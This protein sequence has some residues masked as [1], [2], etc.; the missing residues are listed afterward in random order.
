MTT[1]LSS[2]KP[3]CAKLMPKILVNGSE[4]LSVSY[5]SSRVGDDT[6]SDDLRPCMEEQTSNISAT[7]VKT[8]D[9]TSASSRTSSSSTTSVAMN[10]SRISSPGSE[11]GLER[12]FQNGGKCG[13]QLGN[14][15]G[16]K[17]LDQEQ[18]DVLAIDEFLLSRARNMCPYQSK[19]A[20]LMASS[21]IIAQWGAFR[22][23]DYY[24]IKFRPSR[25]R[26]LNCTGACVTSGVVKQ[27]EPINEKPAHPL[28]TDYFIGHYGSSLRTDIKDYKRKR[29]AERGPLPE[30]RQEIPQADLN[31]VQQLKKINRALRITQG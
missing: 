30:K 25:C 2:G 18:P 10:Q 12:S 3:C 17:F 19:M 22:L 28:T 26:L 16:G 7:T 21:R 23:R 13:F 27:P 5:P 14:G 31:A 11:K 8:D 29:D 1:V 20:A 9:V 15:K 4:W 6:A 24:A